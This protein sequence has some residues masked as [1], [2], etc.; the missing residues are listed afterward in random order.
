MSQL[1]GV[2]QKRIPLV[3]SSTDIAG[4]RQGRGMNSAGDWD[5]SEA[6]Y[7]WRQVKGLNGCALAV[8][9]LAGSSLF[10]DNPTVIFCLLVLWDLNR[11]RIE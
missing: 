4:I 1:H 3:L 9:L 10:L 8:F 11:W 2:R 6:R 5:L 7:Q